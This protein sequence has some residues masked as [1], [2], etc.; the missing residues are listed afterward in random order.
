V[1]DS[2]SRR[3]RLE[4][5]RWREEDV[6]IVQAPS[7]CAQASTRVNERRMGFTRGSPAIEGR[8]RARR[9]AIGG[10]P[11]PGTPRGVESAIG[12]A[13]SVEAG[14]D[15]LGGRWARPQNFRARSAPRDPKI[16]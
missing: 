6:Q 4:N 1:R 2:R 11:F 15:A 7:G 16:G 8:N 13:L 14:T 10:H 5:G 9:P 12:L 3:Q